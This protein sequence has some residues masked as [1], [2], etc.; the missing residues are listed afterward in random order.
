MCNS[1]NTFNEGPG[2]LEI[3]WTWLGKARLERGPKSTFY[4]DHFNVMQSYFRI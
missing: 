1:K 4:T 2:P 3:G